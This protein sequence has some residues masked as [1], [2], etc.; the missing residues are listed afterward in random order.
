MDKPRSIKQN[1]AA[2][3]W[4]THLADSLNDAGLEMKVVLAKRSEIWWTPE[5]IKEVLFKGVMRAMYPSK[6][7]TTQLTTAEFSKVT[8]SLQM[9]LAR[10]YG[11][12]VDVPSVETQHHQ[13]TDKDIEDFY[14]WRTQRR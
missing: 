3:L 10:D 7:S 4:F 12:N 8:E 5:A 11:L 1:R 9:L 13:T 6:N 2:H 14:N